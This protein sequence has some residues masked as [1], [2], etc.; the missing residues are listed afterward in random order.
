MPVPEEMMLWERSRSQ[1]QLTAAVKK[2]TA[3]K[4]VMALATLVC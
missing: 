1:I 2:G 3:A 4:M